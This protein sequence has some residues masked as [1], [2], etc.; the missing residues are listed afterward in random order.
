MVQTFWNKI[1]NRLLSI[2]ES[3]IL[4][5]TRG[6]GHGSD[7]ARI[8]LEGVGRA[9]LKGYHEALRAPCVAVL[10]KRLEAFDSD[11][12]G[13]AI[14]GAAMATWLLDSLSVSRQDRWGELLECV[15]DRHPYVV[16]VG[17]GWALAR[18]PWTRSAPERV[19][20]A[21]DPVL[22][23]LVIDGYGFHEG[24]FHAEKWIRI[25]ANRPKL[26]EYGNRVFDQGLGRSL[27][28]VMG[29]DV[30]Q[31][32]KAIAAFD[33][34][35]QTDLWSGVGLACAYAGQATRPELEYLMVCAGVN[36]T[37]LQQGVTFGA[38]A[39]M[40][41]HIVNEFTERTCLTMCGMD[42]LSASELTRTTRSDVETLPRSHDVP[43]YELWRTLSRE[44]F[45]ER[46]STCA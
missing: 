3:E 8:Q 31:I 20:S 17:V 1:R 10:C 7:T 38:E 19:V 32:A 18:L 28:F 14:E 46:T 25:P 36:V 29:A 21:L 34:A 33:S 24:Y 43:R 9:F 6:F 4:F 42:A 35:R 39:R 12:H 41:G 27:W 15:A 26:S 37:H 30:V 16:H 23:W 2:S 45:R 13:F 44:F 40:R 22:R 11:L 5:E